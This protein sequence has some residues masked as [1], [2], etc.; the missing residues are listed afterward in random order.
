MHAL[1]NS[2]SDIQLQRPL[3]PEFKEYAARDVEDLIEV[4]FIMMKELFEVVES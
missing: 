4:Q 2:Q 1:F 3:N